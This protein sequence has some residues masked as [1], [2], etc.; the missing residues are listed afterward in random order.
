ML[1]PTVNFF[2]ESVT[3]QQILLESQSIIV[4]NKTKF[5]ASGKDFISNVMFTDYHL[6]LH[7]L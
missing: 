5:S 2:A 3:C 1:K 4:N 6:P 7:K